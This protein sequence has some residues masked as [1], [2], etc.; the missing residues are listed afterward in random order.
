MWVVGHGHI[1]DVLEER[2]EK[3]GLLEI[4]CERQR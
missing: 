1:L 4:P 2:V 3:I